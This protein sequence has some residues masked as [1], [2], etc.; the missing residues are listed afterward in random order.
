M[1]DIFVSQSGIIKWRTIPDAVGASQDVNVEVIGTLKVDSVGSSAGLIDTTDGAD[2]VIAPE[3][4]LILE[5]VAWPKV[6][7]NDGDI[8]KTNGAGQSVW[9]APAGTGVLVPYDI[10]FSIQDHDRIANSFVAGFIATRTVSVVTAGNSLAFAEIVPTANITYTLLKDAT[11]VGSVSFVALADTGVVTI[12]SDFTLV[13]SERLSVVNPAVP[14]DT[15]GNIMI[16]I[17]GSVSL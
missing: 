3:G 1:A 9:A 15:I 11:P 8:L 10:S 4:N 13:S 16:T 14:D 5:L 12:T 6:D 7:G 2:L 17:E